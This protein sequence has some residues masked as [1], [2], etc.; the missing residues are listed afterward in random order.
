MAIQLFY[1]SI[2][3]VKEYTLLCYQFCLFSIMTYILVL[4]FVVQKCYSFTCRFERYLL[5]SNASTP[6]YYVHMQ[7]VGSTSFAHVKGE[8]S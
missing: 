2:C 7:I 1:H 4:F 8:I 3:L 6:K 5:F